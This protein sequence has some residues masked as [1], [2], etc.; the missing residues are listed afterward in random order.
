[1]AKAI[2]DN[3]YRPSED[4]SRRKKAL[5]HIRGLIG[6]DEFKHWVEQETK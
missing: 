4:D 2:S 5:A 6:A 1:M 3:R